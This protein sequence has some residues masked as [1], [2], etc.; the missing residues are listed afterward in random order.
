MEIITTTDEEAAC[1]CG[2]MRYRIKTHSGTVVVQCRK[3]G[4][5]DEEWF[6]VDEYFVRGHIPPEVEAW[7]N[8]ANPNNHNRRE[9]RH[10]DSTAMSMST[11]TATDAF[12]HI[13]N[14]ARE[15]LTHGASVAVAAESRAFCLSVFRNLLPRDIPTIVTNHPVVLRIEPVVASLLVM[16]LA[17]YFKAWL[18]Y[19]DK[20]YWMAKTALEADG[21]D[22]IQPILA[23]IGTMFRER[24]KDFVIPESSIS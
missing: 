6:D 17:T 8:A 24:L 13:M 7:R 19:A 18:P 16:F 14:D 9:V 23:R 20:A 4:K 10:G 1:G 5:V 2:C 21:R 3:C 12:K 15:S 22:I 11:P